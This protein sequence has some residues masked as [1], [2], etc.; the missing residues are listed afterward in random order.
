MN[1]QALIDLA[2]E[3]G[4]VASTAEFNSLELCEQGQI[5]RQVNDFAA[6]A[7]LADLAEAMG[8]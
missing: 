1:K 5:L 8:A 3:F 4:L 2:I 6:A 7:A